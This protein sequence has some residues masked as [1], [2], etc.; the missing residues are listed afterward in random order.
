MP[1][2]EAPNLHCAALMRRTTR[3]PRSEA[4]RARSLAEVEGLAWLLDNSIPV[5]GTGGRRFGIDAIIGIVPGVGDVVSGVLGLLVVWRGSRM[6][7][8]RIVVARMLL[9]ALLDIAI[10]AIPVAGDAFDLW[11]K[12]STR[13]LAL[14]RRHLERP[15]TST[16]E[17]WTAVLVVVGL[18]VAVIGAI[19]WLIVAVVGAIIGALS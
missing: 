12:A 7:L 8:P 19:V 5:P 13:N 4:Q 15:D 17:D 14:M 11:F 9:N 18:A 3:A 10:G 6:G 16:R 1:L 2:G